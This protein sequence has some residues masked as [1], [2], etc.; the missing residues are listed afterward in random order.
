MAEKKGK[1]PKVRERLREIAK[2]KGIDELN[3]LADQLIRELPV[4]RAP[5]TSPH[6]TPEIAE[7]VRHFAKDN[8]NMSQQ[9]IANHFGLNHGR[10]S[11][12]L[13]HRI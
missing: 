11:D 3:D 8:P 4:R 7:E 9:E 6:M 10:V 12:A 1:I 2:E 5:I 13:N